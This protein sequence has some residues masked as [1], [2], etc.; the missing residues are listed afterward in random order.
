MKRISINLLLILSLFMGLVG[1]AAAQATYTAPTD[2]PGP[3][4]DKLLFKAFNVDRAPLDLQAGEMD[5][6]YY[7]L[8]IA[9]ARQLRDNKKVQLF[10]A[11]ANTLS[12]ILNP[13][14]APKGQLN[15]FALPRVRK[16]MQYLVD[17]DYVAR[18]IYQGQAEPMFTQNSPT[19]FDSLTV[20]DTIQQANLRYDPDFAK[21]EIKAAMTE[22]GAKLVNGVWQYNGQSVRIKFIIRVEDERRDLGDLVSAALKSA[23]FTV[24]KNYQ[25]FAPA[26]QTVYSTD[27]A[28]Q[29]WHIYTEG[30]GKGAPQRYD[31]GGVNSYY[32]P[33][34]GNMP[35]WQETGFWQYKNDKL[36]DLGK[37]LFLGKFKDKAERDDIYRQ[38]TKLGLDES[39][40]VWVATVNSVY[41]VQ[42]G[43]QGITQDLAAGPRGLWTLRAAYK[44]GSNQLT[45][46][47]LWV[48]TERS[49]WNPVGGIGDVYS[50]D[51]YRELSDPPLWNDPFTGIPVPFRAS[52]KVETA[53]PTGKLDMPKDAFAWNAQKNSWQPVAS[54][55]KAT[56]KVTFD[57]SKFFQAPWHHGQ[58]ITMADVI[59]SIYQGFDIAYNPDKAKI[60]TAM[61]VTSRPTYETFRGF[62]VVDKN[63]LEVY[64]DFWH[65]DQ[66]YIASYASPSGVGT[67]WEILYA[68]DTL[69]FKQRRAA[70]SDTAAARFS[71]P[72]I[73]LV[74]DKDARLVRKTLLDLNNAKTVPDNVFKLPGASSSLVDAATAVARYKADLD[75]FDKYHHLIISNGPFILARY[76]PAAQFAELDAFRDANYP[77]KPKDLYKGAPQLIKFVE[78]TD[79]DKLVIGDDYT[80]KIQLSGPGKLALHYLLSDS[81][82]GKIITQGD[83][84]AGTNNTFTIS[85]PA[86]QTSGLD[87]GLYHL[88]LAAYSDQLAQMAARQV[89]VEADLQ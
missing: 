61:A 82:T 35:G 16:A 66:S 67:P 8:K 70:Y 83:A 87:A 62:R 46:G 40:R 59:Y 77:F 11:P 9:A 53:G 18:E 7:N 23:G 47:N 33:W 6:Y 43:I 20:F 89:D 65:F 34:L 32:A 72:W 84:T 50:S 31:F 12:L 57:Y 37:K 73:S 52:Y 1:S 3:A 5:M 29:G 74:L 30:W 58:P 81:S 54:G 4:V 69:V 76:D 27:P 86:D 80:A 25:P 78:T 42:T 63:H 49:T 19:D 60:E 26:I 79:A 39:V 51:I 28:Q 56:S 17:R 68:L 48:W 24:E 45:V 71:V 64:V 14:P 2:K 88:S 21:S 10:E 15:P 38:M 75:W 55:S 41:G 22:A 36:D 44:K 13:A 85:I